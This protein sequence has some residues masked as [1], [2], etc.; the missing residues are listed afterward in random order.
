MYFQVQWVNCYVFRSCVSRKAQW[1]NK[2]SH[3]S[4]TVPENYISLAS[5]WKYQVGIGLKLPLGT[6]TNCIF[7]IK[8]AAYLEVLLA[9]KQIRRILLE[10]KVS[11]ENSRTVGAHYAAMW[12][13][14]SKMTRWRLDTTLFIPSIWLIT[15][16][17]RC[18][19]VSWRLTWKRKTLSSCYL[20]SLQQWDER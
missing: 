19:E 2:W 11:L 8:H 17:G 12:L 18:G 1:S 3:W 7:K 4:Q 10:R 15:E 5:S 13:A 14:Q 9:W 6:S 20:I 16:F